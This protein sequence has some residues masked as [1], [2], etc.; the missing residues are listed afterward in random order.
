MREP[1]KGSSSS[2]DEWVRTR[3]VAMFGLV[4]S[5]DVTDR[6]G[7]AA[8]IDFGSASSPPE[9]IGLIWRF[10]DSIWGAGALEGVCILSKCV[11]EDRISCRNQTYQ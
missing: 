11:Q 2:S 6:V 3:A 8:L 1:S 5:E 10:N 7:L 4:R 9:R